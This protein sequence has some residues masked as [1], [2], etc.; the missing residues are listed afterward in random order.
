MAA[1]T[2]LKLPEELKERIAPLAQSAGK[3]PHAWMIDAL[4]AQTALAELRKRFVEA[5][6]TSVAEY[7]R[8]G[9]A[10]AAQDVRKYLLAKV[11]GKKPRRPR[12]VKR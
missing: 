11:S 10:Y 2:T 8:T 5:A 9:K 1:S 3:T 12:P 6:L 4:E 7:E